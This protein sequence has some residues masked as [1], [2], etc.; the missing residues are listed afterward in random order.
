LITNH[1]HV[2]LF[3]L[4]RKLIHWSQIDLNTIDV[5]NSIINLTLIEFIFVRKH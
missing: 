5:K 1:H 4:I 2:T 3:S